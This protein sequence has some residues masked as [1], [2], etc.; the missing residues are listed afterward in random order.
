MSTIHMAVRGA[1]PA[2]AVILLL[3]GC[4]DAAAPATTE[5]GPTAA[6]AATSM[7]PPETTT[8]TS[9]TTTTARPTSR[10]IEVTLDGER[11]TY[12][13]P[14]AARGDTEVTFENQTQGAAGIAFLALLDVSLRNEEAAL[15]GTRF[16]VAG[17]PPPESLQLVGVLEADPGDSATQVAPLTPGT[18]FID[19]VTFTAGGPDQVWRVAVLDVE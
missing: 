5:V 16:S 10:S 3:A 11:C 8:T 14:D 17:E 1:L 12:S 15:I 7:T 9:S 4:S 2:L 19:C 13:G 18:Y 6:S